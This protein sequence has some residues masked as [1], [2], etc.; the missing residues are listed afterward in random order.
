MMGRSVACYTALSFA[1]VIT[2]AQADTAWFNSESDEFQT[3]NM[4]STYGHMAA[5]EP[6]GECS[7]GYTGACYTASG[8]NYATE[9]YTQKIASWSDTSQYLSTNLALDGFSASAYFLPTDGI[10]LS[11]DSIQFVLGAGASSVRNVISN[12]AALRL[13]SSAKAALVKSPASFVSVYGPYFVSE[14]AY[15][16]KFICRYSLEGSSLED[17]DYLRNLFNSVTED[18]FFDAAMSL[19]FESK[20]QQARAA[21]KLVWP[22]F[23]CQVEGGTSVTIPALPTP[24]ELGQLFQTWQPETSKMVMQR[25]AVQPISVLPEVELV[26]LN[27]SSAEALPISSL[28]HF[29]S[30]TTQSLSYDLAVAAFAKNSALWAT[31]YDCTK[32]NTS[33]LAALSGLQDTVT[34]YAARAESLSGSDWS[35]MQL[36]FSQGNYSWLEGQDL[37]GRYNSLMKYCVAQTTATSKNANGTTVTTT[38]SHLFL[39]V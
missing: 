19:E 23:E 31:S 7:D 24:F 17:G 9:T 11:E 15:G 37:I 14:L 16:A 27:K 22:D 25:V 30:D 21:G 6:I 5:F 33:L 18:V 8:S 13:T 2:V 20:V 12:W 38:S 1:S 4:G 26:L 35:E 28:Q 39:H 3:Y 36:Q 34:S 29:T 32:T 10:R